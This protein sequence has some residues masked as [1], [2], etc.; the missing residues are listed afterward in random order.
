MLAEARAQGQ[1]L[2]LEALPEKRDELPVFLR[3][4]S[5]DGLVLFEDIDSRIQ[6]EVQRLGVPAVLVNA[7]V[8]NRP[9]CVTYD[10]V[11]A[12]RMAVEHFAAGGKRNVAIVAGAD[13]HHYSSRLR[14]KGVLRAAA[15]RDLPEPKVLHVAVRRTQEAG[16]GEACRQMVSFL[17]TNPDVDSVV[18]AADS[19]APQFYRAAAMVGRRIPDDVAVIGVN[20]SSIALGLLPSLT[21]L[22]VHPGKVGGETVRLLNEFIQKG[23]P[24][25]RPVKL[26][27]SLVVRE[28]TGQGLRQRQG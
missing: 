15:E 13:R 22:H 12:M 18:L 16:C 20:N 21:S 2:M 7:N 28:S 6:N 9:G 17:E 1:V 3:E 4:H 14:R 19:L 11:G 26:D 27:Y 24:P 8:R 10:E 23:R 25:E 5:V